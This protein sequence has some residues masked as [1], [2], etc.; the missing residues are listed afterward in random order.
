MTVRNDQLIQLFINGRTVGTNHTGTM[1]IVAIGPVTILVG[2]ENCIYAHRNE[3]GTVTKYN[4]WRYEDVSSTTSRHIKAIEA[5]VTKDATP[6]VLS[7]EEGLIKTDGVTE[8]IDLG[9]IVKTEL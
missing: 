8:I 4:G 1:K 7:W 5:D 2:F 6:Q 3:V 9:D